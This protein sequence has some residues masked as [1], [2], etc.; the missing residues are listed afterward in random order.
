[1]RAARDLNDEHLIEMETVC[2][3]M[4]LATFRSQDLLSPGALVDVANQI[5]MANI[6]T[7]IWTHARSRLQYHDHIRVDE[8]LAA[9]SLVTE[10]RPH[11]KGL[12]VVVDISFLRSD[13]LVARLEHS[14]IL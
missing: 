9:R 13:V 3:R 10:V 7:G 1:M 12:L 8:S 14:A 6:Q 4:T 5:V 11:P 2:G